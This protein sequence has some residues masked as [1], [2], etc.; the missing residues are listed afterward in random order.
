[1]KLIFLG[2]PGAG[3]GTVSKYVTSK[4]M[5]VQISTGDIFREAVK[6]NTDLG[7]K[8]KSIIEIGGLVPDELTIALIKER[9]AKGDLQ[10]GF[11]L[12]GFPR[13]LQQAKELE[14][15]EKIDAVINFDIPDQQ[16][17]IKR[18]SGRLTCRQCNTIYNSET[19]PPQHE[20]VC[21]KCS[22]ALYT[23]KDDELTSITKRIEIYR[24]QTAPLV[25][26][27]EN[28]KLL[29]KI[30]ASR[31]ENDVIEEVTEMLDAIADQ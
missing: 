18:L 2:P 27:F 4:Y 26:Y 10:N 7:K 11:I 30:D 23:R 17:L 14:R 25:A 6:N 20:N 13:T 31:A 24:E 28:K 1:M 8:V 16:V 21:D 19:N 3:K 29:K 15:F 12:D 9:L 5:L 22:G